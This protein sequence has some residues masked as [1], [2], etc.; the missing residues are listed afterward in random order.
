M[1]SFTHEESEI[2]RGADRDGSLKQT[3]PSVYVNQMLDCVLDLQE[4]PD[5]NPE[6]A[7]GNLGRL[8]LL[9]CGAKDLDFT[10]CIRKARKG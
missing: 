2:I 5:G 1:S 3:P 6:W 8:E 4:K 9:F 10:T 7:I